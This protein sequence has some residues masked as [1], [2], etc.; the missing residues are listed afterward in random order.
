MEII[1]S[2]VGDI[3]QPPDINAF[4]DWNRAK[5]KSLVDKRMSEAEAVSRFIH[6]DDYIG[7]ELYGTVRCPMSIVNEIIRQDIKNL[8]LVGQGVY[9]SDVLLAE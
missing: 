7:T 6:E 5:S 1:K 9:E 8:R 4:R 3:L 2:G